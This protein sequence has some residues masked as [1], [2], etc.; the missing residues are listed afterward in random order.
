L[1]PGARGGSPWRPR[2]GHRPPRAS[3]APGA[4]LV[5]ATV[6]FT[7]A[8]VTSLRCGFAMENGPSRTATVRSFSKLGTVCKLES[9]G[10]IKLSRSS[11]RRT[12]LSS[13]PQPEG[14]QDR[15]TRR[16]ESCEGRLSR[17]AAQTEDGRY[18]LLV[19]AVTDYAHLGFDP[20]RITQSW[21]AHFIAPRY[22]DAANRAAAEIGA[23][24]RGGRPPRGG[25][26]SRRR[27]TGPRSGLHCGGIASTKRLATARRSR[28][29]CRGPSA[30]SDR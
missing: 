2:P 29:Y 5:G 14:D 1:R 21:V 28:A 11:R 6:R 23:G 8:G 26:I 19:E 25:A 16:C 12:P 22:W 13:I 4:K 30:R 9:R 10:R 18:R 27:A 15:P 7:S 17:D 24:R 3:G 20:N